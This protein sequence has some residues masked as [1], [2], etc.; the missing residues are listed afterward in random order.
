MLI[1]DYVRTRYAVTHPLEAD[2]ER[3]VLWSCRLLE[4]W[5]LRENIDATIQAPD[6]LL[7][8]RWVKWLELLYAPRTIKKIRGDVL[9]VL[10][11]AADSDP[12]LRQPVRQRRVRRPA[13]PPPIARA[14][15]AE[16]VQRLILACRQLEGHIGTGVRRAVYF[17]AI[18]RCDWRLGIRRGDLWNLDL[19][20]DVLP[21]GRVYVVQRKTRVLIEG[22]LGPEELR[23]LHSFG[24]RF[25][26]RWPHAEKT[27]YYWSEKVKAIAG[28]D[29]PGHLQRVRK[30]AATD[31]AKT[32]GRSAAT[33]FLGHTNPAADAFYIDETLLNKQSVTPTEL[34]LP[35]N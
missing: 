3:Q 14:W 21:D 34:D 12:P 7:L 22:S 20:N 8:S 18:Y 28:V 5:L 35:P 1:V 4:S 6:E 11:D 32:Q 17:E 29:T 25:P 24:S 2:S 30:S 31:V 16:T 9:G 27:F 19:Q 26:L 23:L 10:N 15:S 33:K 13:V